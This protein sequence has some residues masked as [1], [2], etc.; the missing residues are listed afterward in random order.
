LPRL[1]QLRQIHC[2]KFPRLRRILRRAPTARAVGGREIVGGTGHKF[3]NKKRDENNAERVHFGFL[4]S[5]R[6]RSV[7]CSRSSSLAATPITSASQAS[8]ARK[9]DREQTT[10]R[11][12]KLL[13]KPK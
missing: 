8:A 13:R 4:S 1:L 2:G 9:L 10:E 12:R 5:F 6:S 3:R 11:L 7:V